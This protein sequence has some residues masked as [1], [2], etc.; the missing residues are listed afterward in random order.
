MVDGAAGP[1]HRDRLR[2]AAG[3]AGGGGGVLAGLPE[4]LVLPADRPRPAVASYRGH[5]VA[6]SVPGGV[7]QGVL[8]LARAQ[9]VTLFMVVQ[10]ALAVLLSRLGAGVDV[11]VGAAVAG[12][13]DEAL[14][15]LV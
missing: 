11:P 2:G 6:L 13:T 5:R 7:H 12:R 8:G 10:A 4:E 14:D 9:G 15:E 1:G 3:G